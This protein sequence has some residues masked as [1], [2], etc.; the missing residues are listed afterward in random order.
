MTKTPITWLE[1]IN[2]KLSALKK[3]GKSASIR[4][5]APEAKAE[6]HKIKSGTH[7]TYIQ[8]KAKTHTRKHHK[9]D[10]KDKKDKKTQKVD[11]EL[12]KM[13]ATLKDKLCGKCSKKINKMRGGNGSNCNLPQF[14]GLQPQLNITQGT[15]ENI[16]KTS[17]GG[18]APQGFESPSILAAQAAPAP[19]PA[20]ASTQKGGNC[21]TCSMFGG[22]KK[23]K[24]K[25]KKQHNKK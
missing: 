16:T 9:K 13:L 14:N 5:V 21:N 15:V 2:Q 6:W 18:A 7:P 1:L 24:A 11:D 12:K 10:K 4:D 8:G 3:A 17:G 23:S 20:P 25:S 22:K 19:A